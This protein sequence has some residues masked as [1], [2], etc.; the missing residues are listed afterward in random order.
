MSASLI[1]R[2]R[3]KYIDAGFDAWILKPISFDRLNKL[4]KAIVDAPIR[5]SC[6]Y[7]PGQWE[8]G[9]W[10]HKGQ[11]SSEGVFTKPSGEAPVMNPSESVQEAADHPDDPMAGQE[12]EHDPISQ[13][14]EQLLE[15]QENGEDKTQD[16]GNNNEQPSEPP[17]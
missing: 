3:Q 9:G 11:R 13:E 8:R 10:F 17:T 4:L 15:A 7:K 2:D 6:L 16:E 12:N 5:E 1:E 14:Q